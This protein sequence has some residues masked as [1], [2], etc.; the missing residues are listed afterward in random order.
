MRSRY[1]CW[2]RIVGL[3][4]YGSALTAN[5]VFPYS[6][7]LAGSPRQSRYYDWHCADAFSAF[8]FLGILVFLFAK[9][10]DTDR[11][12]CV[13]VA[14]GV[15]GLFSFPVSTIDSYY[16]LGDMLF[17]VSFCVLIGAL[18]VSLLYHASIKSASIEG[19][20][21]QHETRQEPSMQL[22]YWSWQRIVGLSMYGAL[23][24]GCGLVWAVYAPRHFFYYR[25][26]WLMFSAFAAV[27]IVVM[28]FA[29]QRTL[30][31]A[32]GLLF[33]VV[34]AGALVSISS[35]HPEIAMLTWWVAAIGI[36]IGTQVVRWI[37]RRK[38][39]IASDGG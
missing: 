2:Q 18:P 29:P 20:A 33:G 17:G 11:L 30:N 13:L 3:A 26:H 27:G 36:L 21:E 34:P 6:Y 1:W 15:S 32:L 5:L 23:L 4:I 9:A 31:R 38:K 12:A 24:G 8:A 25:D 37:E 35:E 14:G 22:K 16:S 28:L 10:R 7:Y 39:R 19:A